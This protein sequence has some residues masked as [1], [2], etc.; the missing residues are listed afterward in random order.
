MTANESRARKL[1]VVRSAIM[2][3]EVRG[4]PSLTTLKKN[5]DKKNVYA[6]FVFI[7]V[8]DDHADIGVNLARS[9]G[10]RLDLPNP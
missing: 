8:L 4:K 7:S 3:D 10:A 1:R 9:D 6:N 2:S 5:S